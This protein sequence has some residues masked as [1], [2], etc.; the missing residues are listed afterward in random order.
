LSGSVGLAIEGLIVCPVI[1]LEK[2]IVAEVASKATKKGDKRISL[3]FF[4][5]STH[6]IYASQLMRRSASRSS[7]LLLR[8]AMRSA[9]DLLSIVH[10]LLLVLVISFGLIFETI[11]L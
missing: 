3:R 2:L 6:H 9:F 1:G 10:C 8:L 11:S 5:T 7:G 4:D